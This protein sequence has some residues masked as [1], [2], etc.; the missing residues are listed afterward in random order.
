ME[1]IKKLNNNVVVARDGNGVELI[2]FGKGIG[3]P[4]CPYELSD[5]SLI[6]ETFYHINPSHYGLFSEISLEVF[7]VASEVVNYAKS[8]LNKKFNPNLI[9][10]LADHIDFALKRIKNFKSINLL[11]AY[12]IEQMYPLETEI[13][14]WA[15]NIIAKKLNQFLPDGEVTSIALHFVNACEDS[16][17]DFQKYNYEAVIGVVC[18]TIENYF[19]A[20]I[21]KKSFSYNRFVTHIHYLLQRIESGNQFIQDDGL[22]EVLKNNYPKIFACS[23][24]IAHDF[25]QLFKISLSDNE[26]VYLM[27]HIQRILQK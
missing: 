23:Q 12:D 26:K 4:K 10:S 18:K 3:F 16:E 27:I 5:L 20:I 24:H 17:I 13:G 11:F 19:G 2:A 25:E 6:T 15:L 1:V 9:V 22:Y 14:R 7:E 21:D 8:V